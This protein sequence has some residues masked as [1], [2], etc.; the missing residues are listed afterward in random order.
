MCPYSLGAEQASQE[1]GKNTQCWD[2]EQPRALCWANAFPSPE[3]HTHFP[4]QGLS[5]L[6]E[7][8]GQ[9]EMTR[10]DECSGTSD[11]SVPDIQAHQ[12]GNYTSY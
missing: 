1:L 5:H 4:I 11:I 8:V 12:W 3:P 6:V 9:F 10:K 7:V 2:R